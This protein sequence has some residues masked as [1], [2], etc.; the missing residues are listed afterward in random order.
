[1]VSSGL[2]LALGL[3]GLGLGLGLG[4]LKVIPKQVTKGLAVLATVVV[5][6]MFYNAIGAPPLELANMV[7]GSALLVLPA[8]GYVAG[9]G[10]SDLRG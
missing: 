10:I 7:T 1:M 3:A 5:A 8:L 9:Q 6:I 4:F 2:V